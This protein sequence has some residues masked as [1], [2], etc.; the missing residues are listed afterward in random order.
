MFEIQVRVADHDIDVICQMRIPQATCFQTVG[1]HSLKILSFNL[2]SIVYSRKI[3]PFNDP[4][5]LQL[6]GV[7]PL[8][9]L[10]CCLHRK[11]AAAVFRTGGLAR[12]WLEGKGRIYIYI[13]IFFQNASHVP[14]WA[15]E[16][17]TESTTLGTQLVCTYSCVSPSCS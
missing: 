10:L 6:R 14:A 4:L 1:M 13:Y 11:G 8:Q 17:S 3:I 5:G 7:L 2:L 15:V 16:P 9:G 12:G